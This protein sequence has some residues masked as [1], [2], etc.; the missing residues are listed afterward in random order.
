[1]YYCFDQIYLSVF[2]F[3]SLFW[4]EIGKQIVDG[5][6]FYPDP[7]HAISQFDQIQVPDFSVVFTVKR[8]N[9]ILP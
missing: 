3:I 7:L 8:I 4:T 9:I 1:M 2:H 5:H 6:Y